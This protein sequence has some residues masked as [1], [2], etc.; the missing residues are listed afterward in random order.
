MKVIQ[1]LLTLLSPSFLT[2]Y[3]TSPST[4]T[5]PYDSLGCKSI[6]LQR[7]TTFSAYSLGRSRKRNVKNLCTNNAKSCDINII[8]HV[9]NAHYDTLGMFVGV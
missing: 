5:T 8:F 7:T 6:R 9:L 2:T 3:R 4:H 1:S